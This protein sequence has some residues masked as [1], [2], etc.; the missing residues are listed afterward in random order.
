MNTLFDTQT[1]AIAKSKTI[2]ILVYPNITYAKDL[3]K[4]SYVVYL[5]NAIRQL[6]RLRD[7]LFFYILTPEHLSV[8]EFPNTQQLVVPLLSLIHI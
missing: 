6:N 8:L 7:D 4:D 5:T 1:P 2:R 3:T